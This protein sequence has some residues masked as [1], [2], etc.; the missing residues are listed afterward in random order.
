MGINAPFHQDLLL[1]EAKA[2]KVDEPSR[3]VRI[4]LRSLANQTIYF[5]LPWTTTI[6]ELK[7]KIERDWLGAEPSQQKLICKGRNL[8]S[9]TLLDNEL[10][11][12]SCVFVVTDTTPRPSPPNSPI[13]FTVHSNSTYSSRH[14]SVSV[15]TLCRGVS[16]M[17]LANDTVMIHFVRTTKEIQLVCCPETTTIGQLKK[18]LSCFDTPVDQL[19]LIVNCRVC[20][21]NDAL[22]SSYG[23]KSGEKIYV[24]VRD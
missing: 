1:R 19:L 7:S 17:K 13:P 21:D 3:E 15:D 9:G 5:V 11:S 16:S 12:R 2:L 4:Q 10:T 14:S 24:V 6:P 23:Y 18:Q 22:I 8:T 20:E